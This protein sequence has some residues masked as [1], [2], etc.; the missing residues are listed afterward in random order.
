MDD[1]ALA[2]Q[3]PKD[4][5]EALEFMR[6]TLQ[7]FHAA[8]D[9]RAF[10]LRVYYMMTLEV[11]A[12]INGTGVYVGRPVFMDPSWIERLS[13]RFAS[14]Y[15]RSLT[16]TGDGSAA[17]QRAWGAAHGAARSSRSTVLLNAL[18]GIVAHI[19]KDLAQAI[20]ENLEL[21][22]IDDS[23][24]MLRRRFDHDQV[25]NLLIRVMGSI[26]DT[27][28]R[29]YEPVL[30]VGDR[31]LGGLDERLSSV[32]LRHY[33]EQVWSDALTYAAMLRQP[34][35]EHVAR[36]T[37]LVRAKLDWESFQ[38]AKEVSDWRAMWFVE[39]ALGRGLAWRGRGRDWT[40]IEL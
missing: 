28:A 1:K 29:D 40:R 24:T 37:E 38:L 10:F 21:D 6:S 18:L 25:N 22:D 34:E 32:G 16:V 7:Q 31:V 4:I 33:R 17:G 27:L 23:A 5:D 35:P 19:K 39:R 11:H 26:Q 30:G 9:R 12:A 20:A 14:L 15:F 36:G 2:A 13:G 8:R 3:Q